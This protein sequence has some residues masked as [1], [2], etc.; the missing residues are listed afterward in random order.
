MVDKKN[1]EYTRDAYEVL[2]LSK[3]AGKDEIE[4]RYTYLIKKYKAFVQSDDEEKIVEGKRV[5]EEISQAYNSIVAKELKELEDKVYVKP[6]PVFKKMGVDEKQARNFMHYHKYHFVF[7]LIAV[8]VLGYIVYGFVTKV[9]PD[10]NVTVMGGFYAEDLSTFQ[11]EIKEKIAGIKEPVI[12]VISI[13]KGDKSQMGYAMQMKEIT[14]VAAGGIDIYI[15]EK[16]IFDKYANSVTFLSLDKVVENLNI[17][18]SRRIRG[19]SGKQQE[20]H[21]Y[22]IDVSSSGFLK[23]IKGESKEKIIAID[24]RTKNFDKAVK[25]IE[26]AVK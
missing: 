13:S 11:H 26:L 23:G 8:L 10:F 12:D 14:V 21:V 2:G 5:L 25:F 19:K 24:S 4:K 20:E 15:V 1:P 9:D 18:N 6:N 17:D 3:N 7:G 22:G 16:S